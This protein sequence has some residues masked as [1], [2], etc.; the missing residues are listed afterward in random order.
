M[1]VKNLLVGRKNCWL[2]VLLTLGIFSSIGLGQVQAQQA[3]ATI[4]LSPEDLERGR[5]GAQHNFFFLPPGKTGEDNYQ[6]AG[7][8]GQKLRP[9]LGNNAEALGE[10]ASYRQ[11]KTLYLADK[12]LLAGS[13][14]VYATQVF[15][16]DKAQYFNTTQQ[17]AAGTAVFSLLA[18][19]FINRTTSEHLKQ[20]VSKYNTGL[21]PSGH[22]AL[23]PRLRPAGVGLATTMQGQPI[24]ALRW[25]L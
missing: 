18:T 11:H 14:I 23:W 5:Y 17:V 25:Q 3:P 13:V 10:L 1:N 16:G 6:S 22:G 21:V 9:Y 8:F 4:R 19:L 24:L 20:A 7:F 12:I 15:S 2:T